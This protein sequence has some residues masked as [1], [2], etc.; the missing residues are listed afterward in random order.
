MKFALI[1]SQKL[2]TELNENFHYVKVDLCVEENIKE[3]F[4][5]VK[6]TFNSVDVLVNN[7]GVIKL[8]DLLGNVRNISITIHCSVKHRKVTRINGICYQFIVNVDK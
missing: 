7:A 5:W 6:S 1:Y 8:G 2:K 3:A 4:E